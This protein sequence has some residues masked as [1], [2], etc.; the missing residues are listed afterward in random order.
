MSAYGTILRQ[1]AAILFRL[2]RS[3]AAFCPNNRH[4]PL[5]LLGSCESEKELSTPSEPPHA[6]HLTLTE[7]R[8]FGTFP[9]R[10]SPKLSQPNSLKTNPQIKAG[11]R[12]ALD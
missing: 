3:E 10:F 8:S 1:F 11:T 7:F 5:D 4:Q 12:H 9:T 6:A 2:T